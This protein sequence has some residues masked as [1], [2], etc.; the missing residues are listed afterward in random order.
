M[1]NTQSLKVVKQECRRCISESSHLSF[2][3][4]PNVGLGNSSSRDASIE[5]NSRLY[6]IISHIRR[7]SG[8]EATRCRCFYP[9]LL[10][11]L[12]ASFCRCLFVGH[13]DVQTLERH[14][15]RIQTTP[16]V[17]Q[18]IVR[19]FSTKNTIPLRIHSHH[20]NVTS[21]DGLAFF[22][23][24]SFIFSCLVSCHIP[25]I[26]PGNFHT[27]TFPPFLLLSIHFITLPTQLIS[28]RLVY[29]KFLF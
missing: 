7:E 4:A 3:T 2:Q 19:F 6:L 9:K 22:I 12:P 28:C 23:L 21:W 14:V 13:V 16:R 25:V 5:H 10:I 15:R 27:I 11:L 8:E 17:Q 1:Y 24:A 26:L 29:L 18:A 20:L